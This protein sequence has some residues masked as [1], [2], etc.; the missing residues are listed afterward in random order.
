MNHYRDARFVYVEYASLPYRSE[1]SRAS[2]IPLTR[3]YSI[4]LGNERTQRK[5]GSCV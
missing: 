5:G 3:H 2:L 1:N 4:I